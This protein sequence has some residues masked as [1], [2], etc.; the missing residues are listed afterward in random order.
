MGAG[1]GVKQCGAWGWDVGGAGG[2]QGWTWQGRAGQGRAGQGRAGQ[3]RAGGGARFG[4]VGRVGCDG[5]RLFG[6][7]KVGRRAVSNGEPKWRRLMYFS[8]CMTR[9]HQRE[10][11]ARSRCPS[12]RRLAAPPLL[13]PSTRPEPGQPRRDKLRPRGVARGGGVGVGWGGEGRGG[14]GWG[15]VGWGGV[16]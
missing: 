9:T 16:G 1:C 11:D 3:G 8:W 13:I 12:P 10:S 14:V 7:G 2:G 6:P 15:G 5:V 4:W